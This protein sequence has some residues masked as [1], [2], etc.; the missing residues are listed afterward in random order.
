MGTLILPD[1]PS[2]TSFHLFSSV[3]SST[4]LCNITFSNNGTFGNNSTTESLT[5]DLCQIWTSSATSNVT[6]YTN[7]ANSIGNN[8]SGLT[9]NIKL[10]TNLYNVLTDEQKAILTDKGYTIT[11]G[12]S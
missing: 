6:R 11:Y 1:L 7:L 3:G 5:L 9:R 4:K 2:V 10:N 12:T 8:T